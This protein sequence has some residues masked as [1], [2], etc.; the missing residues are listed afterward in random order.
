[1]L[2]TPRVPPKGKGEESLFLPPS[3][4]KPPIPRLW[5]F[6]EPAE[7]RRRNGSESV[8]NSQSG[9]VPRFTIN[10]PLKVMLMNGDA[11]QTVQAFFRGGGRP[12]AMVDE[13]AVSVHPSD[14]ITVEV[15]RSG[16]LIMLADFCVISLEVLS[17]EEGVVSVTGNLTHGKA[18][19]FHL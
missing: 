6:G 8:T 10:E 3:K 16:N 15:K 1:M 12:T 11:A 19:R 18:K 4:S 9:A 14:F 17:V 13:N 7:R 2:K 5:G